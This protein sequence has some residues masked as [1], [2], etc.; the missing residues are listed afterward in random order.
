MISSARVREHSWGALLRLEN[1]VDQKCRQRCPRRRSL[2]VALASQNDMIAFF[3]KRHPRYVS[4]GTL[5]S[6][7]ILCSKLRFC[8]DPIPL[9]RFMHDLLLRTTIVLKR[10]S[11]VVFCACSMN[12]TK[13]LYERRLLTLE[14]KIKPLPSWFEPALT[15]QDDGAPPHVTAKP[16]TPPIRVGFGQGQTRRGA[17][18]S[19]LQR[20]R[21]G[22]TLR[23]ALCLEQ[24]TEKGGQ[25]GPR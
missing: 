15:L 20:T 10:I 25:T 18:F 14:G 22:A 17:L 16:R 1:Y 11:L 3:R 12:G 8:T 2:I 4:N 19:K 13:A 23:K 6:I 5:L 9:H 21:R 24:R 7:S